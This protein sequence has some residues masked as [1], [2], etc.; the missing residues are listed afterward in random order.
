MK[1]I[2]DFKSQATL[3]I[4]AFEKKQDL[5]FEFFINDDVIGIATFGD[6]YCINVSDIIFDLETKQTKGLIIDWLYETLDQKDKEDYINYQSY[7]KGL[8]YE[9]LTS[10]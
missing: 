5:N 9:D 3:I 10:Q 4:K 7:C 1:I 8:R 6:V 2:E